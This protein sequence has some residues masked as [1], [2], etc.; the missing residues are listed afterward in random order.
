M[1]TC[2]PP[3]AVEAA[4]PAVVFDDHYPPNLE[5]LMEAAMAADDSFHNPVAVVLEEAQLLKLALRFERGGDIADVSE[6]LTP[7]E[8]LLVCSALVDSMANIYEPRLQTH[9][10]CLQRL[11]KADDATTEAVASPVESGEGLESSEIELS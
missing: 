11:C 4:L 7:E 3:E 9:L 1:D 5:E 6:T 8:R 10:N 2:D